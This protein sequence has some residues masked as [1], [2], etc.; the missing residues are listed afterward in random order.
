MKRTARWGARALQ[1]A[2]RLFPPVPRQLTFGGADIEPSVMVVPTRHGPVRCH[3]YRSEVAAGERESPPV[4]L[5]F[6]GG[7]FIVRAPLQDEHACRFIAATTG[8]VVVNVDYDTAPTVQ[9]P[10]AEQQAMDVY[11]WIGQHG[12][13]LGWRADDIVV[14]GFSAG[15][16]LAINVCQQARDA[17]TAIPLGVV[18][19]YPALNMTLPV[20]ARSESMASARTAD[21]NVP[22]VAPWLIGLMYDSYFAD[23]TRRAEPLASPQLDTALSGFPSTLILTGALDS[24]GS[25][26]QRFVASLAAQ[27]VDVRHRQFSASDHGMTHNMPIDIAREALE[28]V[29]EHVVQAFATTLLPSS[30]I[31]KEIQ[32]CSAVVPFPLPSLR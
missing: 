24:V 9:Y 31:N 5:N 22:A 18:A 10:V 15:G 13:S 6:H 17:G 19:C 2:F 29:A 28:L 7:A 14:G 32:S 21:A 25:E 16:K 3:V 8:A 1:L 12:Y 4:Y 20:R 30:S 23:T 11:T 26:A 27:G